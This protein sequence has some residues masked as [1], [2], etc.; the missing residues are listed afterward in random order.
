MGAFDAPTTALPGDAAAAPLGR[1]LEGTEGSGLPPAVPGLDPRAALD[2]KP[3]GGVS[4]LLLL[5]GL[6]VLA[7]VVLG[8]ALYF[9][10]GGDDDGDATAAAQTGPGSVAEPHARTTG[11]EVFYPDGGVDQRWVVE[12]L[13]PVRDVTA[14]SA[15][16][17]EGGD[18]FAAIR[19][20][21]RNQDG[22]DGAS[23]GDLH[24]NA[25]TAAGEVIEREAN[26][27]SIP[28]ADLDFGASLALVAQTV[29][30]VCW[31]V[32]PAALA[33]LLLGL[34]SDKVAGRVHIALQ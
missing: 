32:P 14:E 33:G 9:V 7:L 8:A 31:E 17:P 34:E 23:L 13:E 4:R 11:V 21:V 12:V 1:P 15:E 25:V 20:R 2:D 6:G 16:I 28:G 22:V 24:F 26:S 27:C 18:V 30:A 3:K 29:G 19:I 10:F 5:I